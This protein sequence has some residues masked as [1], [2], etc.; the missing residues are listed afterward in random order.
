MLLL[1]WASRVAV[2]IPNS[3]L[4]CV[5]AAQFV[6]VMNS[7]VHFV[8]LVKLQHLMPI[9]AGCMRAFMWH[10]GHGKRPAAILNS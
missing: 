10:N 1:H 6:Q 3:G 5:T 7:N 9:A 8:V 4:C 2:M